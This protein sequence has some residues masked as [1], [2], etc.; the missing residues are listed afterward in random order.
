M[1][2]SYVA[3]LWRF[4][5]ANLLASSMAV[6]LAMVMCMAISELVSNLMAGTDGRIG[7]IIFWWQKG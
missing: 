2:L 1:V 5:E 3:N 7:K 4:K 6:Q